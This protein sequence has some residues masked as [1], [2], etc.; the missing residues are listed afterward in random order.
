[1]NTIWQMTNEEGQRVHSFNQL[2]SLKTSHF[3]QIFK[4]TQEASLAEII[5][6]AGL[7]PQFV[8][9]D[10][11]EDLNKLVFMGQLECTLIW[12][13]KDK[14]PS[15]DGWT[16]ELYLEFF[17]LLGKDLL[18][19]IEEC[20]IS[21]IMYDAFNSTF[22]ALI[23]KSESPENLNDFRPI[24]LCNFIYKIISKIITNCLKPILSTHISPEQFA[25]LNHHQIH[26]A[27][28]IAQ[29]VLHSINIKKL[30][31]MI[32][33]IDLENDFDH[34]NWLYLRSLLT[35]QGFH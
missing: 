29:E 33:N 13:K 4:A 11:V 5:R 31:G 17:E 6:V 10:V 20:K 7:L 1:M 8:D 27:I 14:I 23:P 12:F 28:G 18:Q 19:V 16:V 2:A 26:D 30:K 9:H 32:L 35:H 24:S 22:I 34:A 15:H 21:G 25:F 3:S